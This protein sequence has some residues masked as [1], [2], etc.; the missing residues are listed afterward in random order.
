MSPANISSTRPG[1]KCVSCGRAITEKSPDD[2]PP[3]PCCE[4]LAWFSNDYAERSTSPEENSRIITDLR[5]GLHLRV[6]EARPEIALAALIVPYIPQFGRKVYDTWQY[7]GDMGL[8]YHG[9]GKVL[10][11]GLP[12]CELPEAT[13]D[14]SFTELWLSDGGY[15]TL[16]RGALLKTNEEDAQQGR[17]AGQQWHVSVISI[18]FDHETAHRHSKE[19]TDKCWEN[20]C[21]YADKKVRI[22]TFPEQEIR[23]IFKEFYFHG[24]LGLLCG[25]A[26]NYVMY[27]MLVRQHK[28]PELLALA[29]AR[30]EAGGVD[31]FCSLIVEHLDGKVSALNYIARD[32]EARRLGSREMSRLWRNRMH[33]L[34][35]REVLGWCPCDLCSTTRSRTET[36][37]N[38][39]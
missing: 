29:Q 22:E 6:T 15:P 21:V 37:R 18:S 16:V 3:C 17:V 34:G 31:R 20:L 9:Y 33:S 11:R 1:F 13:T 30:L 19:L 35:A 10:G 2:V 24:D 39:R 4:H 5:K 7:G 27:D 32:F 12:V 23:T 25:F 28:D 26:F 38:K 14:H 36:P 8:G